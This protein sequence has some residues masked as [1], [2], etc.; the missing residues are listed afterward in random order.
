MNGAYAIWVVG[1]TGPKLRVTPCSPTSPLTLAKS[2]Y[3][4]A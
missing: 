3:T 2:P 4:L 1:R